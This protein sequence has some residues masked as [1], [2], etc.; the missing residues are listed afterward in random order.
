LTKLERFCKRRLS[1]GSARMV[2]ETL[3]EA[4]LAVAPVLSAAGL[5]A[6]DLQHPDGLVTGDQQLR[7]ER[8]FVE[9]TREHRGL[10]LDLGSRY[11]LLAYGAFGL[12][13]LNARTV[14]RAVEFAASFHELAF[15]VVHYTL[16]R[17]PAGE[18]AGMDADLTWVPEDLRTFMVE[19][20]LAA[21]RRLLDDM[22]NGVFPLREIRAAIPAPPDPDRYARALG[23]PVRFAAD[24]TQI[25]FAS[26]WR[27]LP[28]PYGNP[29]LEEAYERQ[30][31]ELIDT[32]ALRSSE[33]EQ[34]IDLLVRCRGTWPTIEETAGRIAVSPRTLRRRLEERGTSYRS[35]LEEV[36]RKQAE[37]LLSGTALSVEQIADSLGYAETASFT[38]AFKRWTGR[39]PRAFR[40][41]AIEAV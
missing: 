25:L 8:A 22:V 19:R 34:V 7:L 38:H 24:R 18:I 14:G 33:V 40:R 6:L 17:D 13:I 3:R 16:L 15:T 32:L 2:V 28:M 30:C 41:E 36:R 26:R 10:W 37:E 11:R 9:R 23:T 20:D 27:T 12:A 5:R 4:G 35:L 39:A 21:V 29:A 31:R 1:N